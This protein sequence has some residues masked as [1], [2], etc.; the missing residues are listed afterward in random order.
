MK[1]QLLFG[2]NNICHDFKIFHDIEAA[3]FSHSIQGKSEP[4][5]FA[6]RKGLEIWK[7]GKRME[8]IL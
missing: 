1:I 2:K 3:H 4:Q 7:I 6:S 8:Q 5:G